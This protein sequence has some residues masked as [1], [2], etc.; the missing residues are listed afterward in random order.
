MKQR[1]TGVIL[2]ANILFINS[3]NIDETH[4]VSQMDA[5]TCAGWGWGQRYDAHWF[6]EGQAADR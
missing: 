1:G 6:V 5:G 4:I 2:L 3:A